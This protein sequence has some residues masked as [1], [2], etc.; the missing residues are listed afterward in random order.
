MNL[1]IIDW[2]K[3]ASTPLIDYCK[4]TSHRI[5]GTQMVDGTITYKNTTRNKPDAIVINYAVKPSHGRS[6]AQEMR[7]RKKTA[8]TPIYF[9][10][11][12]EDDNEKVEHIGICLSEEEFKDLLED[13]PQSA[14]LENI[15]L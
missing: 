3:E 9:I 5:V 8:T 14:S 1:F 10:N 6:A 2:S 11:G 12:D 13:D 15:I 7:K 4:T